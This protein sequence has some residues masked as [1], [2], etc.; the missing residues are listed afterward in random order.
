VTDRQTDRQTDRHTDRP[1]YVCSNNPHLS[2]SDIVSGVVRNL[3][4]S[5][6]S[7]IVTRI[8]QLEVYVTDRQTDRQ[9]DHA[10][11]VAIVRIG[12]PQT[13]HSGAAGDRETD[14]QA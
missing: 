12:R 9:T 2:F 8:L 14:R 4:W 10:T 11:C 5:Q 3:H 1:R 13:T 7:E 6:H